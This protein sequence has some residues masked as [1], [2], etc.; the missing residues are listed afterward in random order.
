[1]KEQLPCTLKLQSS[2]YGKSISCSQLGYNTVNSGNA[3]IYGANCGNL[4][5]YGKS[6]GALNEADDLMVD[7][8]LD[9][10]YQKILDNFRK[11]MAQCS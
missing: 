4:Y 5:T 1:M 7:V 3:S 11:V 9:P 8:D 10:T 6:C 2:N